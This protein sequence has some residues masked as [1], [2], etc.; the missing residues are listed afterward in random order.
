L[1]GQY[2][3]NESRG[4][5]DIYQLLGCRMLNAEPGAKAQ[6][7]TKTSAP[8]SYAGMEGYPAQFAEVSTEYPT[9]RY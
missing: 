2:L 3:Q 5:R 1:N 4:R 6:K 8:Q 7:Q 9:N